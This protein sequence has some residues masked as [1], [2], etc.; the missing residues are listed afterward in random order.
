MRLCGERSRR[1]KAVR[2][3]ETETVP[4]A[5]GMPEAE[6]ELEEFHRLAVDFY[7]ARWRR[8]RHRLGRPRAAALELGLS[9]RQWAQSDAATPFEAEANVTEITMARGVAR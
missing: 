7:I 9:P 1:S 5:G 2:L 4:K 3:P 8:G 6:S